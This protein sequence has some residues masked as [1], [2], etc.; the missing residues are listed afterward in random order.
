[1]R[2]KGIFSETNVYFYLHNEHDRDVIEQ[3]KILKEQR[4]LNSL[5]YRLLKE[6]FESERQSLISDLREKYDVLGLG[7][8]P[9]KA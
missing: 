6:H 4:K 3:V 9:N 5:I 7:D 1:M 8:S 2:R